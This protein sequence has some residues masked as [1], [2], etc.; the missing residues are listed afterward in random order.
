MRWSS[1]AGP[2]RSEPQRRA[3]HSWSSCR[4]KADSIP[5]ETLTVIGLD[6]SD[7]WF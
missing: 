6:R 3:H 2:N 1:Q 4:E 5:P 7:G